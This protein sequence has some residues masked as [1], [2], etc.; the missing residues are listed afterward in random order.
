MSRL[1]T[2]GLVRTNIGAGEG[3]AVNSS[4]GTQSLFR[5]VQAIS[6]GIAQQDAERTQIHESSTSR[7]ALINGTDQIRARNDLSPT[8]KMQQIGELNKTISSGFTSFRAQSQ[9]NV[10][11][12]NKMSGINTAL[13]AEINGL[14]MISGNN[15]FDMLDADSNFDDYAEI[16]SGLGIT[17]IQKEQFLDKGR[18]KISSFKRN[19]AAGIASATPDVDTLKLIAAEVDAMHS[20][21]I[22]KENAR[23]EVFGQAAEAAAIRG[24]VPQATK[25]LSFLSEGFVTQKATILAQAIARQESLSRV[26]ELVNALI[27]GTVGDT[28]LSNVPEHLNEAAERIDNQNLPT[29]DLVKQF[30]QA[31]LPLA[32]YIEDKIKG[33][34]NSGD[35]R[36]G[37]ASIQELAKSSFDEAERLVSSIGESARVPVTVARQRS[38]SSIDQNS[39]IDALSNPRAPELLDETA[40]LIQGDKARGIKSFNPN[41]AVTDAMEST[42]KTFGFLPFTRAK[43]TP[44]AKQSIDVRSL[45]KANMVR[46]AVEN[47]VP[48]EAM[49]SSRSAMAD[50]TAQ[51]YLRGKAPVIVD[52]QRNGFGDTES[53]MHLISS[54]FLRDD[55]QLKE[56][57]AAVSTFESNAD[58]ILQIS[59]RVVPNVSF[60]RNNHIFTPAVDD[61]GRPVAFLQFSRS[62]GK[63][64]FVSSGSREFEFASREMAGQFGPRAADRMAGLKRLP[65]EPKNLQDAR[66][67]EGVDAMMAEAVKRYQAVYQITPANDDEDVFQS[68]LDQTLD[69]SGF[70]LPA[71]T[72]GA[73]NGQVQGQ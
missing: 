16:I 56:F 66:G 39:L 28:P 55:K 52:A 30:K 6:A 35:V 22:G 21:F 64:E 34:F 8:E 27:T 42:T 71:D 50:A 7:V 58:Q 38:S 62:T 9:Y 44:T 57:Q 68:F 37:L 59:T 4:P 1:G 45:F 17:A 20:D 18:A 23:F 32:P 11:A 10:F 19:K 31:G 47:N 40:I 41:N 26:D 46:S 61:L 13:R 43:F 48:R 3:A 69:D 14:N 49:L 36:G 24:D 67:D 73:G 33:Q 60:V 65:G 72:G 25:L 51:A 5:A 54:K 12:A 15:E 53:E 63:T 70:E 2:P 29:A